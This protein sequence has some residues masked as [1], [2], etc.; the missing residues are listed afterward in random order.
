MKY[1]RPGA[2]GVPAPTAGTPAERQTKGPAPGFQDCQASP[3]SAEHG[4]VKHVVS[5]SQI[6]AVRKDDG[7]IPKNPDLALRSR[8]PQPALRAE[9]SGRIRHRTVIQ[10]W[11]ELYLE[12]RAPVDI[13]VHLQIR[14]KI[15]AP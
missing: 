9:Q 6:A 5:A 3:H 15:A 7:H 13:F 8:V 11:A 10:K 1:P 14:Q 12:K 4:A 2:S